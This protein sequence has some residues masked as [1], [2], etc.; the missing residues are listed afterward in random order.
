MPNILSLALAFYLTFFEPAAKHFLF[1]FVSPK[2]FAFRLWTSEGVQNF[3]IRKEHLSLAF[4][5]V[6]T[7]KNMAFIAADAVVKDFVREKNVFRRVKP[8]KQKMKNK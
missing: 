2:L 4:L 1:S 3:Y 7:N 8:H 6:Y 5:G